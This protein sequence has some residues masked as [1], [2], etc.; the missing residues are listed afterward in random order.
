MLRVLTCISVR[1]A[2]RPGHALAGQPRS[3]HHRDFQVMDYFFC[4]AEARSAC[5]LFGSR[6][7][8]RDRR[9]WPGDSSPGEPV[10]T[11][12]KSYRDGRTLWR[13]PARRGIPACGF[14]FS[15]GGLES[16]PHRSVVPNGTNAFWLLAQAMNRL[17]TFKRPSGAS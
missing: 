7:P 3:R 4:S 12:F 1:S 5:G 2:C 8:R 9:K 10:M 17:A 6:R 14:S 11:E 15:L 16:P 13:S